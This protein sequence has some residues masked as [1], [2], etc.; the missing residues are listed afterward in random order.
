MEKNTLRM[1]PLL[2][3]AVTGQ[4]RSFAI[5][6]HVLVTTELCLQRFRNGPLKTGN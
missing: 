4:E 2:R 5:A 3:G 6:T 1:H